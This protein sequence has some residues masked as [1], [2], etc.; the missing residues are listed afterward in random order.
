MQRSE[1][2]DW[3]IKGKIK[4]K[5]KLRKKWRENRNASTKTKLN[6]PTKELRAALATK[7]AEETQHFLR[8]LSVSK[9]C[10]YSLWKATNASISLLKEYLQHRFSSRLLAIISKKIN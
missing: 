1:E 8:S 4:S 6:K 10:D 3:D 2:P 5:H 7:H 9:N